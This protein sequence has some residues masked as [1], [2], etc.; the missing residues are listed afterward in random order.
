M[1]EG[2][3]LNIL[4]VGCGQGRYLIPLARDHVVIGIDSSHLQVNEM[5]ARGHKVLHTSELLLLDKQFDYIIM[6]HII[7]HIPPASIVQ[8]FNTYLSLLKS[9][10]HLLIASPLL[11]QGFYDD[12]DHIKPYTPKALQILFSDCPQ[13]QEKPDYR[14][15]LVDLWMR[16]WPYQMN[17]YYTISKIHR[18]FSNLINA[19]STRAFLISGNHLGELTGY[20]GKFSIQSCLEP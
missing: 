8:F 2:K 5:R 6:S 4:D 13:Q 16:R 10:G 7:E 17:R 12:Y 3:G 15:K 14:L 18:K 9:S 11:H 20:V 1:I 19:I